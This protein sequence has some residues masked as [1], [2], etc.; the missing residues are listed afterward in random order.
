MEGSGLIF[1]VFTI[2]FVAGAC[3]EPCGEAFGVG[4][5]G[6]AIV[7]ELFPDECLYKHE[8]PNLQLF[9][10]QNAQTPF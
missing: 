8:L 6:L 4:P 10:F 1:G 9:F 5:T 7:K 3:G 2:L